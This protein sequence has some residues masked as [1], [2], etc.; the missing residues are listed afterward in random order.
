MSQATCWHA[1]PRTCITTRLPP[2]S[3][4]E[5]HNFCVYICYIVIACYSRLSSFIFAYILEHREC[6]TLHQHAWVHETK[7]TVRRWLD[8][9]NCVFPVSTDLT[10]LL[11]H[12]PSSQ[13]DKTQ[14]SWSHASD[15][16]ISHVLH[17]RIRFQ[18]VCKYIAMWPSESCAINTKLSQ[19]KL[20]SHFCEEGRIK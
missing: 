9:S 19:D 6:H 20:N 1:K 11:K 10:H 5:L 12:H 18:S 8:L 14:C 4:M 3:A 2:T 17:V 7:W 13:V 15:I 16:R